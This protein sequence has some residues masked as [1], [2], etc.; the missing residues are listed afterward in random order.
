MRVRGWQRAPVEGPVI[1]EMD[2]VVAVKQPVAGARRRPRQRERPPGREPLRHHHVRR[3]RL[4][5]HRIFAFIPATVDVEIE[6]VQVHRVHATARVDDTH[7]HALSD[8]IREALRVRPR[9][10]VDHDPADVGAARPPHEPITNTRSGC[11]P[12]AGST[13]SA[14][15]S[16]E[17]EPERFGRS[18]AA[19]LAA[20]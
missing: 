16:C 7:P 6:P 14:P 8:A 1:R 4:R 2:V 5:V 11:G 9:Q 18:V 17:S 12:P 19:R 13:M 3:R 20:Q 15:D 10:A